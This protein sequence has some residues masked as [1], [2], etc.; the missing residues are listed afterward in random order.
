ME[1]YKRSRFVLQQQ[2]I[3]SITSVARTWCANILLAGGKTTHRSTWHRMDRFYT[4]ICGNKGNFC[5]H[6]TEQESTQ[7]GPVRG[8]AQETNLLQ[9]PAMPLQICPEHFCV[10]ICPEIILEELE[11]TQ[12]HQFLAAK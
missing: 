3:W 8:E 2:N 11:N 5:C 9:P 4:F 10:A 7:N 6:R 12:P 1:K